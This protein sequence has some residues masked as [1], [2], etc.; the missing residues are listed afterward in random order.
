MISE[1]TFSRDFSSFWRLACPMMDG[2]I[3]QLNRGSYD[4]DFAPMK[5]ETAPNRRAFVNEVAF[6]AFCAITSSYLQGLKAVSVEDAI[7]E[8][9]PLVRLLA[10]QGERDGDYEQELSSD[11]VNDAGEQV[12]RLGRR[13]G[14][15]GPSRAITC[16]PRFPGC[17][18]IDACEGDV[19]VDG[20][21]FEI[22]AGDR[23]FRSIDLRQLLVYLALNHAGNG[24]AIRFVGLIN[25]RVGVSFQMSADEFCFEVSGR[26]TA[27][28]LDA[29]VYGIAS[30][31]ISR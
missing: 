11:E 9:E 24:T 7:A 12:R 2:F 18:I 22:K 30:G 14:P 6:S 28:L 8:N 16:R 10:S 26:S 17:G 23:S 15:I 5:V 13:L 31:D 1:I 27:Q 19:L 4:R 3:R 20:I 29:V 25:P 21:L